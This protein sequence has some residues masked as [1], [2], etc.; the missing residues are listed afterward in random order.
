MM[1]SIGKENKMD[2]MTNEQFRTIIELIIQ[3]VKDNNKDEA[4]RKIEALLHKD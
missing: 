3:I 4:I 1:A 2:E